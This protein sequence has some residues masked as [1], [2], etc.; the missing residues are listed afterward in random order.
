MLLGDRM[1]GE[2]D[3]LPHLWL[4]NLKERIHFQDSDIDGMT[5]RQWNLNT[6][7][8]GCAID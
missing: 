3:A 8:V 6:Q 5:I 4:E 7:Y 1:Y 2:C